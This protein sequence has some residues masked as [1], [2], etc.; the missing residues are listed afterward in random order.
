MTN[1]YEEISDRYGKR[2]NNPKNKPTVKQAIYSW[3]IVNEL[4]KL[5]YCHNWKNECDDITEYIQ[6]ISGII[7]KAIQIIGGDSDK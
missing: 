5:G 2:L 1:K 3:A 7:D 4:A 6:S